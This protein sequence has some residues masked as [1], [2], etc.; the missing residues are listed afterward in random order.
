MLDSGNVRPYRTEG[1]I[2]SQSPTTRQNRMFSELAA[3]N[4]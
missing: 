3:I 2:A 4:N 1:Q